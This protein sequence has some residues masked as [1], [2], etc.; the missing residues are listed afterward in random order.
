M[1]NLVWCVQ[2]GIMIHFEMM[3]SDCDYSNAVNTTMETGFL[4][5]VREEITHQVRRNA[6]HPSIAL[7]LSNNEITADTGSQRCHNG[8]SC[9]ENL[10]VDTIMDAIVAEDR[11]RP[12][13]PYSHS[14]GWAAG[15]EKR[16]LSCFLH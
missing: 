15:K 13:W 8:R 4:D 16:L 6:H 11:S 3:F 1:S 10:F 12:L 9:W 7:W 2:L 5:N 14:D